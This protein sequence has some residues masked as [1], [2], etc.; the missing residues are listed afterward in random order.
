M[1]IGIISEGHADRAVITNILCGHIPMERGDIIALRPSLIT[2]ETDKVHRAAETFSSWTV[3]KTECEERQLVDAFLAFEGQ[4]YIVIHID[5][6]E[7]DE[8]GV[9]RPEKTETYCEELYSLVR[10]E[11]DNWLGE[12]DSDNILYAIAIEEIEAWLLTMFVARD[13][14]KIGD[15]KKQFDR[16]L[17][18]YEIDTTSN[19]ENFLKIGKPLS[20]EKEI[21]KGKY[22]N[23][24][25]SLRAF[26]EE[27]DAKI[28]SKI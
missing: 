14:A 11:M 5:T 28:I 12:E 10:A 23:Y 3:V 24:N 8:Y 13:T 20:K 7:A 25:C 18:K 9:K 17:G 21:K 26:F 27:I 16:L 22:L 2:D 1:R 6:A 4:D 15:P 19:Y